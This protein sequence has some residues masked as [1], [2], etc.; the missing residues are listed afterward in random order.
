MPITIDDSSGN[1]FAG[2]GGSD[3]DL[4][5]QASDGSDR[6]RLDASLANL[7]LGGNGASGD[8]VVF[9]AAGDNQDAALA[10]IRLEGRRGNIF[11]G[12]NGTDGD[13]VLRADDGAD[14]IRLDA[15]QANLWLGGNGAD[16]DLVIFSSTGDNAT[17]S[18]ATIHLNGSA[19]DIILSNA[20]CAEDFDVDDPDGLEP[21]TVVEI[22]DRAGLRMARRSYSRRVAG[23]IAGAGSLR[24]GIVLGRT[25]AGASPRMPVALVGRAYCKADASVAAIDVGDLLTTSDTPGHAMKASDPARAF[26]AV[27]GKSLGTLRSGT[28]LVPVLIAL[29]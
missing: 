2:G 20:D 27:L 29:Q 1:I 6:I 23:I 16:G 4:V 10:T 9:E 8:L 12:G 24:P 13:L 15:S 3:G 11:A 22:G 21:G 18:Q 19:G 17:T 7:W 28:G 26:G 5:L 14:R 25:A